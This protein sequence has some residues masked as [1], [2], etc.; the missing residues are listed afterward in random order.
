VET[1]KKSEFYRELPAEGL[2]GRISLFN[3]VVN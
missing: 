2:K 3:R 1:L